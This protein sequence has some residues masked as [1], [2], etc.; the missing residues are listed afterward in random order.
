LDAQRDYVNFYAYLHKVV[1]QRIMT[2]LDALDTHGLT[3]R[4]IVFRLADHGELGLSHGMREK[5]YT[6][7]EEMIHIPLVVSNPILY[8][9]P[10]ETQA[11]YS[12]L[13]LLP[14]LAELAGVP[15]PA[16]GGI[17]RSMV[18]VLCDPSESVQDSVL[19]S[20]DDVFGLP[21][22]AAGAN[23]RALRE[24]DWTYAVYFGIDGSGIEYELYDLATD[25]LQLKNLL[26]GL[27]QGASLYVVQGLLGH[28]QVRMTQRYAHLA[29]QT[30]LDTAETVAAVIGTSAPAA[31]T[32]AE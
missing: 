15:K 24:R 23:L 16:S 31:E 13:D 22:G 14:T 3:E 18:P 20:Y 17:G 8:P 9:E 11:F 28:S 27:P 25:P 6:A 32:A 26:H 21:A 10:R 4:T 12:H 1:D 7:Y 19:F 29:P 5:S 30:L 2:I